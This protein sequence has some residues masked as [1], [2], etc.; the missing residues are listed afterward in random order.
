VSAVGTGQ[1]GHSSGQDTP[2]SPA[3]VRHLARHQAGSGASLGGRRATARLAQLVAFSFISPIA[4]GGTGGHDQRHGPVHTIHQLLRR[5]LGSARPDSV[6]RAHEFLEQRY[7]ELAAGGDFTARL[8]QIYLAGQLDPVGA[9]A[10]WVKA[11]DQCLA[12]GRYDRCRAMI[13]L[14][15][16]LPAGEADHARFTY[17]VARLRRLRHRNPYPRQTARRRARTG[18]QHPHPQRHP[19]LPALPGR[20]RVRAA[21]PALAHPPA[22][23]GQPPQNRRHHPR[24][25]GADPCRTRLPHLTAGATALA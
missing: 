3:L 23:H 8:E 16:D 13:T 9:A 5:A 11:M 20:T 15:A 24:R 1:I 25:P 17:R 6:R 18:R 7:D 4:S 14:L 2:P 12:A 10:E 21:Q 22:H 19:A